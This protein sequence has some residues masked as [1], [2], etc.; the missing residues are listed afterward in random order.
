VAAVA[1]PPRAGRRIL[2]SFQITIPVR[3]KDAMVA[4]E[5]RLLSNLRSIE[6]AIPTTD[7]WFPVF[8]RYVGQVA[9]RVDGLGGDPAKVAPSPAGDWQLPVM[10]T[11][12][13]V[14]CLSFAIAIAALLAMLVILGVTSGAVQ[15]VLGLFVLA[16]LL[17]VGYAWLTSCR[18]TGGRVLA[19]V[20]VGLVVGVVIL[21]VLRAVGP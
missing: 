15:V 8:R 16:L 1:A 3:T 18:P 19:T 5:Q 10:T 14:T 17:A 20:V 2:G 7:R 13:R 6:R 12:T 9:M 21:L 4:A 11:S